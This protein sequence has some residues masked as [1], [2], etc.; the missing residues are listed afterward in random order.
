L[1]QV[2]YIL[3]YST[4][5]GTVK[6]DKYDIPLP[7]KPPVEA[8][9][10][11][12]LPIAEQK[13]KRTIVPRSLLR[14]K[15]NLT[16]EEETFI[17]QEYHKR[18]NGVWMLIKGE[19]VY[20]T[21]PY[22]TFLNYWWTKN[23][24]QP[25]FRYTQSL[26]FLFWDMVVRDTNAYGMKLVK[27]RRI[28]GTE[29]TLFILWEYATRV[30][31]VVCGMQSKNE[32]TV[33]KNFKRL[34]YGNKRVLWFMR[35]I[36][37]GSEDPQDILEF[38]YPS[39]LNTNKAMR[40]QADTGTE[41]E[42]MFTEVE[43]NSAIDYRACEPLAYDGEE[44]NRYTLN[45]SGKLEH[46]SLLDCWDKVKPCLHYFD[47]AQIVGKAIFESTIEELDDK[48]I[49][50]V[51]TLC[52][53]SDP[54]IRDGNGRTISGLYL[55]FINYLDAAKEDEFG[56]PMKEQSKAFHDNKIEA[57]KKAKKLKEI[58]NLLRKE[59]ETIEDALMPSGS[60]SA[61]NKDRLQDTLKRIDYPEKY[62]FKELEHTVRGNFIWAGGQPDTRVLFMEHPDGKFVVS[63]LLK[64]GTE[65]ACVEIAG[66]KHPGNAYKYRGGV[67]PYEHDEVVDQARASKGAGVIMRMYDDNEDGAKKNEDG[68]PIDFAWEW[69]SKQPVCHYLAR[70]D[71]PDTFFEDMLMMHFYYGC[72]MNVENNKVSIKKHFRKRGY[73]E[74][75]MARPESTIDP[76]ARGSNVQQIG[77]PATTD[78]IDQ[79]FN[80]IAHYVMVYGN[81]I[82]H[83]ELI[84]DLLE[85]NKKNRGR[86]I[87]V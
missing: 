85:L 57:L 33:Y 22:Y 62:G 74:Y 39:K 25:D 76:N 83:R 61:F 58:S 55:L 54:N 86:Q 50:E 46:M 31:N 10:N 71:D 14:K 40:E 78:T 72:Q 9:V 23:G 44:L 82:K 35:P 16:F 43:M 66:I 37:K 56:M 67:D 27:P 87:W 52:K 17:Q 26:I 68:S 8:M 64:P 84:L 15:N 4:P 59:P 18:K 7:V 77:T 13:F 75:L 69:K 80:A 42:S 34:T 73:H 12:G 48:Q 29:M 65:C 41:T 5:S 53:D 2:A 49:E 47:G 51:N 45:E 20:L 70:E 24:T 1:K 36:Q 79:Y 63:Q 60:Q 28:G 21:G 38:R 11:Y 6:L 30:R 3:D 32:E 81:A 19:P